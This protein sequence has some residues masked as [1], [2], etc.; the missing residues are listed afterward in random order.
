[1]VTKYEQL[2]PVLF[3]EGAL[4]MLGEKAKEFGCKKVLFVYD[5]GVGAAGIAPKAEAVMKEA[6]IDFV[7]FDKVQADPSDLV[8]DEC[9]ALAAAEG[10]DGIVGIGGGSSMDCAKATSVMLDKPNPMHDYYTDPPTFFPL[11]VPLILIPTTAGTGSECTHVA[12]ITDSVGGGKAGV[13]LKASL[14]IIDP[15]LTY[16][17]PP[18]V[19]ANTGLDAFCHAAE[20]ITSKGWNL[21]SEV[22][23]TDA[24]RR[25]VKYLPIAVKDGTNVEARRNMSFAANIA[26]IAFADTMCH[27][28]HCLA[29]GLSA[30]YHTAH[31][32]NC[33][34][35]NA[36]MLRVEAQAAADKVQLVG[37]AMGLSFTGKE[38]PEEIGDMVADAVRKL[39]REC[40]VKSLKET[41]LTREQVVA[42]TDTCM[43]LNLGLQMFS[44]V[45]PTPELVADIYGKCFDNYQ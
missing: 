44:P 15:E 10:I 3:G 29:D 22:L 30:L 39:M 4:G 8:V 35:C 11:C 38:T 43:R 1:M 37:E 19:T 23:A 7:V 24:I 31:G 21:H 28:G 16:T 6:G 14:A 36:E 9:K 34:V 5:S 33:I 45:T 42:C 12:V 17:A 13:F 41:G 26:G 32:Y 20:A 27:L 25:I 2:T 40:G 18:T